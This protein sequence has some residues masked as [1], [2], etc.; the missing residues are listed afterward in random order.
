MFKIARDYHNEALAG[1][2]R[3]APVNISKYNNPIQTGFRCNSGWHFGS[4]DI[5]LLTLS[6]RVQLCA[7]QMPVRAR[8][9]TAGLG[10]CLVMD[11]AGPG[12]GPFWESP[13]WVN[14]AEVL[15]C[16]LILI[17]LHVHGYLRAGCTRIVTL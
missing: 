9:P 13:A 1:C 6:A 16:I 17:N 2:I 14:A 10:L 15:F 12:R 5:W 4:D 11:G 7:Y 3:N 8:A